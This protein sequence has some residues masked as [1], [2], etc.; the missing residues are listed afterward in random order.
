MRTR[1][2]QQ[3]IEAFAPT[4]KIGIVATRNP[5][6]GIHLTLLTSIMAAGPRQVTIGQF[7][8]GV[9]KWHMQQNPRIAFAVA[10]LDRTL[11]RG[12][13]RWTHKRQEGPEHEVYNNQPMFRYNAYFGI[14]TVHYLDLVSLSEPGRLPMASIVAAS[15]LTR[16]ARGAFGRKASPPI[17]KPFAE[18]LFNEMGALKFLA[19]AGS[20]GF[21]VLIP[22]IQCQAADP[23]RLVFSKAAYGR[24]LDSLKAGMEL[25]VFCVNMKMQSVLVRGTFNGFERRRTIT[26]GS[27]DIAWV[28][29]SMPPNHGQIYPP[30]PLEAVT[31]F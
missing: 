26:S 1:F 21:P 31:D 10:T 18:A 25:S 4:E 23:G 13:A 2:G 16:A 17:L 15:L 28:Y 22:V 7:C 20:D 9:S 14:D 29:N 8:R 12:R 5:E 11:W 30:V 24:E 27:M 6:G 19:H 3:E